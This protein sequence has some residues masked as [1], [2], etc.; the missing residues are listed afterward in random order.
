MNAPTHSPNN[1]SSSVISLLLTTYHFVTDKTL[2]LD[3]P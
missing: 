3:S 2:S 1:S